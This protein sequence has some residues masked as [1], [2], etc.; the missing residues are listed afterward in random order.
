VKLH[1]LSLILIFG[2]F[3]IPDFSYA[4][5]A[6]IEK[7]QW[8]KTCCA[9]KHIGKECSKNCCKKEKDK[10][11]GGCSGKCN[12]IFC[13]SPSPFFA[14][15]PSIYEDFLFSQELM[16]VE[17]NFSYRNPHYSLVLYSIWQPPKIN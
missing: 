9:S 11:N 12:M 3:F 4:Y 15:T 10:K 14:S 13:G 16:T 6:H 1:I 8:E 7:K 2:I 17:K 5:G